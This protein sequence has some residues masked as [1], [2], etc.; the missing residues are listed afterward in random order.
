MNLSEALP[1]SDTLNKYLLCRGRWES[2]IKM[3]KR[4]TR[5]LTDEMSVDVQI[6]N[7]TSLI[8]N[9]PQN[10]RVI[11]VTPELASYILENLNP[12]NRSLKPINIKRYKN[13][14]ERNNW[15]LTGESIK[16]GTDGFLK[17]GQNR[18]K[19][20]I[21]AKANFVTHA[22]FGIDPNTFHH[23]DTGK[24]RVGQDVLKILGVKNAN[25]VCGAVRLIMCYARG[26]ASARHVNITNGA[27][28]DFYENAI[29]KELIQEAVLKGDKVG[30]QVRFPAAPISAFYYI[31]SMKGYNEKF[32]KFLDD[33]MTGIGSQKHPPRVL[34]ETIMNMKINREPISSGGYSV[35]LAK[36]WNNFRKDKKST[37]KEILEATKEYRMP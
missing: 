15:S 33:M 5:R 21:D 10:S 13:D 35:M 25:A 17:D 1:Y 23:M 37:K 22:M 34:L 31:A 32:N 24:N 29:D 2:K 18:L 27:L 11:T 16:F 20:C 14:M 19:A 36:S 7:L 3:L 12:A 28:K 9:P 8:N 26:Y 4:E 30:R 6:K